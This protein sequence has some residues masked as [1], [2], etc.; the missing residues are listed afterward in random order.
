M[1]KELNIMCHHNNE[2]FYIIMNKETCDKL[3][4][5]NETSSD[6]PLIMV[7]EGHKVLIDN[8]LGFGKVVFR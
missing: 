7:Y 5:N 3:Y 6:A 2:D 8:S 4:K 1:I